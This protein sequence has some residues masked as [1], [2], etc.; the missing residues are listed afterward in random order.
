MRQSDEFFWTPR[1]SLFTNHPGTSCQWA[2]NG[3]RSVRRGIAIA[4]LSSSLFS[5][6]SESTA[7][8]RQTTVTVKTPAA[9]FWVDCSGATWDINYDPVMS[10][11]HQFSSMEGGSVLTA[12]SYIGSGLGEADPLYNTCY[13]IRQKLLNLY[14]SGRLGIWFGFDSYGNNG[15]TVGFNPSTRRSGVQPPMSVTRGCGRTKAI[16]RRSL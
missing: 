1:S 9:S 7:P 12:I 3:I 10:C 4:L 14:Y 16:I 15:M 2:E 13:D 6:C 5:A 11:F 8:S